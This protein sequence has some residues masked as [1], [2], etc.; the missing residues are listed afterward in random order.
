MQKRVTEEGE[1]EK[2]LFDKFMCYCKTG[3]G[4]LGK[5]I[6]DAETKI[7]QLESDIKAGGAEKAQL[8]GDIVQHKADRKEAEKTMAEAK[9]IREKTAAAFEKEQSEQKADATAMGKAVASL[10]KGAGGFLQTP[11]AAVLRRLVV[12]ADLSLE[13]RD[14]LTSFLSEG[15]N[16]EDDDSYAPQSGEITGILKQMKETMEKTMVQGAADEQTSIK[17]FDSLTAA[18]TKEAEALTKA[19]ETKMA[20]VGEVGVELVSKD[21]DLDDTG[22]SLVEDKNVLSNLDKKCKTKAAEYEEIEK[23]RG[24]ELIALSDTIKLLN[25]DD[26]LEL[27]KKALPASSFLQLQV[28]SKETLF[29]AR[30]ALRASFGVRDYRLDLIS[31]SMRGKKVSFD[32]VLGM[33][34]DMIGL[35]K[36]EQVD[37]DKKKAYCEKEF[38]KVEDEKKDLK[39]AKSDMEKTI[40]DEKEIIATLVEEISNLEAGIKALDKSVAEATENRKAQNS[41]Y[42]EELAANNAAIQLIGMAKNRMNKFYNPKLYRAAPKRELGEADR[43][44]VNM[45]GTLAPTAAPGGIAGTDIM[46]LTETDEAPSLVQVSAHFQAHQAPSFSAYQKGADSSGVLAMMDVLIKDVEKE[47]AEMQTE[48][49]FDQE[50]YEIF[51]SDSAKKRALDAKSVAEKEATKADTA[52]KMQKH[53]QE[54]KAIVGEQKANTEYDYGLHQECDWLLQNFD[55]RKSARAGEADSLSKAKAVLNGADYS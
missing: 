46:A 50:G 24:E 34:D 33:V 13:T 16:D 6:Q 43:I 53:I 48:E 35:L 23:T 15:S 39:R 41:A 32:K 49:K 12:S 14:T 25:D 8:E 18:K 30:Q 19:L 42:V 27:F 22:K 51:M 2:A 26:A 36:K 55:M 28:T 3:A 52:A 21:E 4:S 44:T 38:D 37:D 17:D 47:V 11:A 10:E 20:R 54:E 1:K 5:S 31:M 9:A 29:R 40:E 45:G 7:P